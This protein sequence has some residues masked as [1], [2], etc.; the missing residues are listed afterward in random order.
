MNIPSYLPEL[1][2]QYKV[3]DHGQMSVKPSEAQCGNESLHY[4]WDHMEHKHGFHYMRDG[5]DR[6]VR[7]YSVDEDKMDL[8]SQVALT[9]GGYRA[10][11]QHQRRD[12][13]FELIDLPLRKRIPSLLGFLRRQGWIAPRAVLELPSRCDAFDVGPNGQ[14]AVAF[15]KE[16]HLHSPGHGLTPWKTFHE[17]VQDVHYL[18]DGTLAVA[19][20]SSWSGESYRFE[21]HSPT[22]ETGQVDFRTLHP[23]AYAL[24][25]RRTLEKLKFLADDLSSEAVGTC[26][27]N[28]NWL[29]SS[30]GG[31]AKHDVTGGGEVLTF[32]PRPTLRKVDPQTGQSSQERP[33]EL[34]DGVSLNF[35]RPVHNHE[36]YLLLADSTAAV[37]EKSTGKLLGLLPEV[38]KV[39]TRQGNIIFL[40]RDGER[41]TLDF[42]Q[43]PEARNQPWY[44]RALQGKALGGVAETLSGVRLEATHVNV[45]GT[46]IRIRAAR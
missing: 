39:D 38:T 16:V 43:V 29:R 31:F 23:E 22:G 46:K 35:D 27:D 28:L 17:K 41:H 3:D 15:E 45:G 42:E 10:V 13:V 6:L 24:R 11:G 1:R 37:W 9:D 12:G 36:K 26:L 32:G 44:R 30:S 8:R 40:D 5:D 21:L 34:P 2:R 20:G 4:W 33:L 7:G 18:A 25:G 14:I 19:T